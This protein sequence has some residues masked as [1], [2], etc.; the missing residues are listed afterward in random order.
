[1]A[2]QQRL[3]YATIGGYDESAV[4]ALCQTSGRIPLGSA[5]W[6]TAPSAAQV[7]AARPDKRLAL[8]WAAAG[9]VAGLA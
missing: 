4:T 1:M 7:A 5:I 6:G 8:T 2:A 9:T 3:A